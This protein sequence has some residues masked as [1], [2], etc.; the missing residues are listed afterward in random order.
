MKTILNKDSFR[1]KVQRFF[2]PNHQNLRQDSCMRISVQQ[3]CLSQRCGWFSPH[4]AKH[5]W[6]LHS[7]ENT[8][9]NIALFFPAD[10]HYI[11]LTLSHVPFVVSFF[12]L[13]PPKSALPG[14][15]PMY[16]FLQVK[17]CRQ[18]LYSAEDARWRTGALSS[19]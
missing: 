12:T 8:V 18:R 7:C 17:R 14:K 3:Q 13:L 16:V 9:T 2:G 1:T 4:L 10:R 19:V 6:I 15:K 11:Q 5:G